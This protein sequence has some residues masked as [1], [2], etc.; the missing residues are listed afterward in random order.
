MNQ[1]ND[2]LS[3]V[4]QIPVESI[5]DDT[6]PETVASWDSFNG[7]LLVSELEQSFQVKFTMAEIVAVKKV[8]DIKEALV[9]HG[10]QL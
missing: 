1:L 5:T 4:L 6:S 2:I 7:L 3:R 9:R 8:R 10:V